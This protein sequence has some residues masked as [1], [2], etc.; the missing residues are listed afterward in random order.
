MCQHLCSGTEVWPL[1]LTLI[2]QKSSFHADPSA[3]ASAN[4]KLAYSC[5]VLWPEDLG[6]EIIFS[7]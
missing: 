5:S 6:L 7:R 1:K 2:Y 3:P 4:R